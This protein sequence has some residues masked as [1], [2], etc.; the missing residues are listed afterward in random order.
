MQLRNRNTGELMDAGPVGSSG[1]GAYLNGDWEV[2][3]G[4]LSDLSTDPN[5]LRGGISGVRDRAQQDYN[6]WVAPGGGGNRTGNAITRQPRGAGRDPE[7]AG[8]WQNLPP[9]LDT[10]SIGRGPKNGSGYNTF[11]PGGGGNPTPQP[12]NPTMGG[13]LTLTRTSDESGG[14][15]PPRSSGRMGKVW[16]RT[17]TGQSQFDLDD[18]ESS[19]AFGAAVS[20]GGQILDPITQQPLRVIGNNIYG[21]YAV[22]VDG[23]PVPLNVISGEGW[24]PYQQEM[25]TNYMRAGWRPGMNQLPN[26]PA[27]PRAA[28][29]LYGYRNVPTY[30]GGAEYLTPHPGGPGPGPGGGPEPDGPVPG[31]GSLVEPWLDPFTGESVYQSGTFD[32]PYAEVNYANL[33]DDP[34]VK[35]RM[36]RAL[37][38]V[39]RPAAAAGRSMSGRTMSELMD[40]ASLFASDELN[41]AHNRNLGDFMTKEGVFR[42]NEAAR[43]GDYDRAVGEYKTRYGVF[44][45]NQDRPFNKLSTVAGWGPGNTNGAGY[46][47]GMGGFLSDQGNASAYGV[48]GRN[49]AN[50]TVMD[51]IRDMAIL[52][53]GR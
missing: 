39:E 53:G 7:Y 11:A 2:V 48:A 34:I 26:N 12:T 50:Q 18:P 33:M 51:S 28:A 45:E 8:Q 5:I 32:T 14:G 49:N 36:D 35:Q 42:R 1:L 13:A 27:M 4:E 40:R 29:E 37:K 52:Y 6:A 38:A 47:A 31:F 17:P 43:A 19:A 22:E 30:E 21:G 24:H 20:G 23:I 25:I 15:P 9:A 3:S 44:T 16:V 46:A 41:S 10:D